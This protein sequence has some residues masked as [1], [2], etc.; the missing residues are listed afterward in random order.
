MNKLPVFVFFI[1]L[2]FFLF[3]KTVQANVLLWDDFKDGNANDGTPVDWEEFEGPGGDWW[4]E[5]EEYIGT[6]LKGGPESPDTPSYSRAGNENWSD[7][8]FDV[9]IMGDQG[10]D[11]LVLFRY[12]SFN[13]TYAIKLISSWP[14]WYGDKIALLKN[15]LL[16]WVTSAPYVNK[17]GIW[18]KLSIRTQGSNIRVYIND[19]TEPIID[20]TDESNPNLTGKIALLVWPG[21]YGGP[22]SRTTVRFDDVLVCD[23]NGPCEMPTTTPTPTP[24][25]PLQPLILLPG[26]GASWN[27]EAMILGQEKQPEDWQMTPGVKVYDDL[28]KTLQ[29]VG[30]ELGENLFIY[31][32]DWRKP[33]ADAA[34]D[35]GAY[36]Q[37][38]IPADTEFDLV[39]H[40]Q[41]G[42]IA[43]TYGQATQNDDIDQIIT[44]GAPLHGSVKPY[45]FW[46]G[47]E[48]S[49][50]LSGWQRIGAGIWLQYKKKGFD[51]KVETLQNT[52]PSFKDF[53]PDFPFLR[54]NNNPK[55]L[56]QMIERNIWLE[57]LN[58]SIPAS[59][60]GYLYNHV[61]QSGDTLRWLDIEER[62]KVDTLL[63]KWVD[64]K[65][66]G[67]Q[68]ALGDDTVLSESAQL[69]GATIK[70]LP[71]L[72][73]GDIVASE[74]GQKAIL[75][76]LGLPTN[77]ISIGANIDPLPA[78]VVQ[79]ASPANITVFNESNQVISEEHQKL[80]VLPNMQSGP[81]SVRVYPEGA[82][83]DY[84]LLMGELTS[85]GDIW[86]ESSG[87]VNPANQPKVH[88]IN[89]NPN[90]SFLQGQLL[91]LARQR[92]LEAKTQTQFLDLPARVTLPVLI[93]IRVRNIEHLQKKLSKKSLEQTIISILGL[94]NQIK[95][96]PIFTQIKESKRSEI[97]NLVREARDYLTQVEELL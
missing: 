53:L 88:G 28:I 51:N 23:F 40:S 39:G 11:K 82:G 44:V 52:I 26:I 57:D 36:I 96:I 7:Y 13:E 91:S 19:S 68:Y 78:L 21:Y 17:Q 31:N 49:K 34:N 65:P 29:N 55:P 64:G 70:E 20:Y 22:W 61:G 58:N 8:R 2:F 38:H 35:L 27:H 25:P 71:G 72:D 89:F 86:T 54:E 66:I 76:T 6:V 95:A 81:Y 12:H 46:E 67:A 60:L 69:A 80:V 62:S 18:Y 32:Y 16:T 37:R 4:V 45:Y 42:L 84:R 9:N 30:Y 77:N 79:V 93:E 85:N 92:L 14:D 33:I 47:A 94:E 97:L 50:G 3:S 74:N 87:N 73:H 5:N 15:N 90:Q 56:S 1:F 24:T 48:L 41:G 83:G 63:G 10:V 75:E 59:L 43:R